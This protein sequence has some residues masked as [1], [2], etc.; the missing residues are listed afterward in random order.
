MTMNKIRHMGQLRTRKKQLQHQQEEL[1]DM[2]RNDWKELKEKLRY[3]TIV[4]GALGNWMDKKTNDN[5]N[6]GN[7][8]SSTLAYGA[9]LLAKKFSVKAGEKF[10]K[11]FKKK[12]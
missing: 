10:G 3:K 5:I 12:N 4:K 11:F 2:I 9:T 7:I 1:E 8:F 6:N